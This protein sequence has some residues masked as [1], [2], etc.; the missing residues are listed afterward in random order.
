MSSVTPISKRSENSLLQPQGRDQRAQIGV[1][2]TFA[3]TIE[4]AL[5]LPR[6]GAHRGKRIGDRLLGVVMGVDADVIA[7]NM[8]DDLAD[9]RLDFMRHGAAIGVAQHHPA[10]AGIIG[11]LRAGQCESRIFLIAVEEML[12]VEHHLAAGFFRSLHAVANRG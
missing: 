1:A 12:A 9:D 3:E 2:A 11:R 5:N 4:R 7:G 6:A 8:L 10:R